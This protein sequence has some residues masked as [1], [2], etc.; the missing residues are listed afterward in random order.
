MIN[1]KFV[2]FSFLIGS[3]LTFYSKIGINVNSYLIVISTVT[4]KLPDAL[5]VKQ[6]PK[7]RQVIALYTYL[8]SML[9][10][11]FSLLL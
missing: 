7:I 3:M 11:W 5:P 4:Y 6:Q 8:L 10:K 2:S 9:F 1:L